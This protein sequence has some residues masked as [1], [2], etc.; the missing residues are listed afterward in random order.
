MALGNHC[1]D[2]RSDRQTY[3]SDAAV[4]AMIQIRDILMKSDKMKAYAKNN[5]VKDFEF[6]YFDDIDDALIEGLERNQDFFTMLLNDE[7]IKREIL[8][9]FTEEIYNSLKKAAEE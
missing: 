9:I 4:K 7:E 1:S 3:D 2:K 5:T 6:S 8:G